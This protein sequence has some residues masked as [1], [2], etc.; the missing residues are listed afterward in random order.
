MN[1]NRKSRMF[2]AFFMFLLL[3]VFAMQNEKISAAAGKTVYFATWLKEEQN[4]KYG[5]ISSVKINKNSMIVN[6]SLAKGNT[7]RYCCKK[8]KWKFHLSSKVKFYTPDGMNETKKV[9]K[10]EFVKL[11]RYL[12]RTANCLRFRFVVEND[13]VVKVSIIL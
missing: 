11:C 1:Y 7:Q 3:S 2:L 9:S 5:I 4:P 10:K 6:G 12:N 13:K 8:G